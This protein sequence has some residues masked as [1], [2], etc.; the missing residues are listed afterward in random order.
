MLR[1]MQK[2][3][4]DS[5]S[6]GPVVKR[7]VGRPRLSDADKSVREETRQQ[8]L[9]NLRLDDPILEK[10]PQPWRKIARPGSE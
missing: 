3:F 5:A 4:N 1:D 9:D 7:P 10:W 6:Q 8:A 2:K